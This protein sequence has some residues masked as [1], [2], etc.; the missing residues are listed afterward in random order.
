M[1]RRITKLQAVSVSSCSD[2]N[3]LA[4]G[5]FSFSASLAAPRFSLL[6]SNEHRVFF[7]IRGNTYGKTQQNKTKIK[8]FKLFMH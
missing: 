7:Q 6:S 8:L 5:K 2:R 4:K 3:G 1:A